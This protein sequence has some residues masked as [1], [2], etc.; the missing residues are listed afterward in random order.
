MLKPAGLPGETMLVRVTKASWPDSLDTR[1]AE[2]LAG[3]VEVCPA[4][5]V[6]QSGLGPSVK[7]R[8]AVCSAPALITQPAAVAFLL[9]NELGVA[10]VSWKH[11]TKFRPIC[12][13]TYSLRLE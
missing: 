8:S 6:K 9:T 4:T 11:D 12:A 10:H 3:R 7:V 1:Q 5:M 13:I 2:L